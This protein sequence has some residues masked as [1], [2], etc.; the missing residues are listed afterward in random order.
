LRTYPRQSRGPPAL[1]LPVKYFL[2]FGFG[3]RLACDCWLA[4]RCENSVLVLFLLELEM[5]FPFVHLRGL[6]KT[7]LLA[8]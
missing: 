2:V 7:H 8:G 4:L 1:P 6:E 5:A 3:I